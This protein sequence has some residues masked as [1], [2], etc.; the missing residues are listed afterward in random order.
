[1]SN[2]RPIHTWPATPED[3]RLIL[4]ITGEAMAG[5]DP[6]GRCLFCNPA[7]VALLGLQ[8][9][10]DLVG[11]DLDLALHGTSGRGFRAH[12]RGDSILARNGARR[13]V[14]TW[15]FPL[16]RD[17]VAVGSLL[18][19]TEPKVEPAPRRESAPGSEALAAT[20]ARQMA[21]PLH[22]LEA[23]LSF[24]QKACDRFTRLLGMH[25]ACSRN[26][27]PEVAEKL[28]Q[29]EADLE[30]DFFE[31]EARRV[32]AESAASLGQLARAVRSLRHGGDVPP[33]GGTSSAVSE[34]EEALALRPG[35]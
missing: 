31:A 4:D 32:S 10:D 19:I 7:M 20:L 16:R 23:D 1:M 25:R 14:D 17:G 11:C 34:P 27:P 3:F 26:H 13:Q 24:L 6:A 15:T 28:R 9:E 35:S 5:M 2:A 8:G 22:C 12:V 21:S 30:V 33:D 29:A 18:M